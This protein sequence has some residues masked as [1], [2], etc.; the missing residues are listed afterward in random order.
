MLNRMILTYARYY[1]LWDSYL[2]YMPAITG[3]FV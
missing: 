2:P 3:L 1:P